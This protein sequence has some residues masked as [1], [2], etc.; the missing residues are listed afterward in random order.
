[1]HVLFG[2][3]VG[4]SYLCLRILT[5]KRMKKLRTIIVGLLLSLLCLPVGAQDKEMRWENVTALNFAATGGTDREAALQQYLLFDESVMDRNREL[6]EQYQTFAQEFMQM[7][8]NSGAPQMNKEMDE[9]IAHVKQMMKEHPELADELKGQLKEMERMRGEYNGHVDNE[10]KEYTY[11]PKEILRK[12]TAIAVGKRA[13]TDRRDIGNGLFA[14]K[15][16]ACYGPLEPDAF[17]RVKTDEKNECTW[18][19]IDYEG[20]FIIQPKYGTFGNCWVDADFIYLKTKDKNGV[21]R[22]GALGYDGRVR[23]PFIYDFDEDIDVGTGKCAMCKNGMFGIVTIDNKLLLPFEYK[24][25]KGWDKDLWFISK[26]G[27]NWGFLGGDMKIVV[28][29]KY[30]DVWNTQD[31]MI[32]MLRFDQKLDVYDKATFKFLRTEPKPHE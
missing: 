4:N 20:N 18:G 21:A 25:I 2:S 5:D 31:D 26:D 16:G 29:M 27:K 19:A 10:V 22:Y 7:S 30:Q 17:K 8:I 24:K 14:V 23:M 6:F 11:D 9:A 3:Y 12:M 32:K 15:T 28:P 1:M 13:F